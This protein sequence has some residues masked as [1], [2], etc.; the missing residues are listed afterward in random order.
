MIYLDPHLCQPAVNVYSTKSESRKRQPS[1]GILIPNSSN[2]SN[3][4][5]R[6]PIPTATKRTER[7]GTLS[8]FLNNGLSSSSASSLSSINSNDCDLFDNS[9]FH[10]ASPSKTSFAKL[11]PSLALGFYCRTL[12]DFQFLCDTVQQ[13]N[14]K[15]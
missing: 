15:F 4:L 14:T 1:A 5:T 2:K 9:S 10:C 6:S 7:T 12:G 13:V 11:D 8:Y 3:S